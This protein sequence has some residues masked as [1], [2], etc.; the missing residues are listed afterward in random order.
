MHN[1]LGH[2]TGKPLLYLITATGSSG[3]LLFGYDNGVF[4][5]INVLPWFLTTFSTSTN[6]FSTI[7]A[8]F[9]VGAAFG[10]L[11][12]FLV[13][14]YLGRRRTIFLGC[15][16]G[17]VGSIIQA[18]PTKVV[19]LI[20]G[21]IIS[22]AGVGLLT[23]TVGLWQAETTPSAIRGR[24]MAMQL[25]F[26]SFGNL[27]STWINYA[28][29]G[30]EGRL[31]FIFPLLFQ[32]VFI[33]ITGS[34]ILLLP[35]SPRWLVKKG[36]IDEAKSVISRLHGNQVN[37]DPLPESDSVMQELHAIM[38]VDRQEQETSNFWGELFTTKPS[39][40][41]KRLILGATV[42]VFHQLNGVN[43][44]SYYV[45]TLATDFIHAPRSEALWI[46]GL[47]SVCVVVFS[48]IPV[49]FLDRFGRRV[50]LWFPT[51][52]QGLMFLI[53]AVLFAK[54]P[55][56]ASTA[57]NQNQAYGIG[58]LSLIFV[59][60][61]IN[62]A[63]WFGT[64]WVYPAELMPLSLREKGMGFA[65]IF[66][67]LFDF[68]MVEITPIALQNISYRFYIILAVFN[69]IIATVIYFV[70]PETANKSLEQIEL[71]YTPDWQEGKGFEE[72]AAHHVTAIEAS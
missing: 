13:G 45:P 12:A 57:G 34:L 8:I 21:R 20:I 44:V 36:R 65:V 53:V 71:D 43:S 52:L 5:G 51:Y 9:L 68:M 30:T 10:A 58:I 4:S 1:P 69:V 27:L 18:T 46:S 24:F 16:I 14:D 55:S 42:M 63:S 40:N 50:F 17:G 6:I 28:F 37:T 26:G 66:Y 33:I 11:L 7:N 72:P 15:I 59:F 32:L 67:W 2:I 38:E 29:N 23:S 62:N 35:E 48:T 25:F 19:Q 39:G 47:S 22:G 64:T 3:F 49:L 61:A 70:F 60:F 56:L 41:R 31:P 54:A